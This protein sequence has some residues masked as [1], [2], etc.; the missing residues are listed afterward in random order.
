MHQIEGIEGGGFIHRLSRGP[1]SAAILRLDDRM[2]PARLLP[3]LLLLASALVSLP[4]V[5]GFLNRLHPA[6]D[7]FAHFR[8]H[9][10]VLLGLAAVALLATRFRG[11]G[12]VALLLAIGAFVATP[13]TALR[14]LVLP[15]ATA[16]QPPSADRAVY[17]LLQVNARFDNAQPAR[18]LSLIGRVRPDVVTVNEVSAMW[19]TRLAL[20]AHAYPHTVFCE[21]RGAIGGVAILS[22]RPFSREA[23][24]RCEDGGTLAIARVEFAGQTADIAALHLHWPWPFG[25]PAQVARL[26]PILA[27]LPE[28]TLLAG[29]FNAVRWSRAVR[30]IAQDGRLRRVGP[31][32]TTWLHHALPKTLRSSIGLGIDHVMSGEAVNVH[33]VEVVEDIAS[34][35]LRVLRVFSLRPAPAEAP[36][37]PGVQTVRLAAGD[38][39]TGR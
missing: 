38:R 8:L 26:G 1:D 19:R 29:D 23:E 35:H 32:S 14:E 27:G 9:L 17:R 39:A 11:E 2:R 3:H 13:G 25:Q 18:L 10:A 37:T 34:D 21:G 15:E 6:L 24:P 20:I 5:A 12:A 7:S 22:R 30:E 36:D 28:T 33:S 16:H 4:L 31:A